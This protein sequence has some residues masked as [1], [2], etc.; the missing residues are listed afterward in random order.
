MRRLFGGEGVGAS[1]DRARLVAG[2][3]G[4]FGIDRVQQGSERV[5][6]GAAGG[7]AS[8]AANRPFAVEAPAR[9][10]RCLEHDLGE[11]LVEEDASDELVSPGDAELLV[12]VLDVGV[13]QDNVA[14]GL[15]RHP[16]GMR[17][18]LPLG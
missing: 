15:R 2:D 12:E 5:S 13:F 17:I 9:C 8:I 18:S 7:V 3:Y 4:V 10:E 1:N 14:G 6:A 16:G 11:V